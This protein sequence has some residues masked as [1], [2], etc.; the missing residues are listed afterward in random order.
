MPTARPATA[1]ARTPL[2]T[3][4]TSSRTEIGSGRDTC[5]ARVVAAR[6]T[7]TREIETRTEATTRSSKPLGSANAVRNWPMPRP[8]IETIM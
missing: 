6:V 7:G 8:P 5:G 3:I 1:E 2:G 4:R